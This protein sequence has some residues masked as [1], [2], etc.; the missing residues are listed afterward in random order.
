MLF[1]LLFFFTYF[2]KFFKIPSNTWNYRKTIC[3]VSMMKHSKD[4]NWIRWNWWMIKYNI[5]RKNVSSKSI[6][7]HYFH[8]IFIFVSFFILLQ[9][10]LLIG[11]HNW[12]IFFC[13]NGVST[14]HEYFKTE[15]WNLKFEM[16][17]SETLIW[18][19]KNERK[20]VKTDYLKIGK[21]ISRYNGTYKSLEARVLPLKKNKWR[22]LENRPRFPPDPRFEMFPIF[23]SIFPLSKKVPR[24]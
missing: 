3:S 18:R 16:F 13:S 17:K 20:N 6:P 7:L 23:I 11:V 4:Y 10:F 5:Y 22:K 9:R 21:C 14:C 15:I 19:I 12:A 2:Q 24:A 1:F 8:L